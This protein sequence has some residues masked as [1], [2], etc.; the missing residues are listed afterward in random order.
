MPTRA[1]TPA[2]ATARWPAGS[3]QDT[4]R[5][6]TAADR[7]FEAWKPTITKAEVVEYLRNWQ[8]RG[9]KV[10]QGKTPA[11]N[12]WTIERSPSVWVCIRPQD[13]SNALWSVG[14][15]PLGRTSGTVGTLRE[16]EDRV[17]AAWYHLSLE[18]KGP[19][20]QINLFKGSPLSNTDKLASMIGVEA[21]IQ[22]I[23]D[24]HFDDRALKR[25]V[26]LGKLGVRYDKAVV[27]ILTSK[28]IPSSDL[29]IRD[30]GTELST[31]LDVRRTDKDHHRLIFLSTGECLSPDMGLNEFDNS[32]SITR[33]V[34]A[35]EK[36]AAFETA[37]RTAHPVH[38]TV[39]K[40]PKVLPST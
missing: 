20:Q 17:M 6:M 2:I 29:P 28:K 4:I 8:A 39:E 40:E 31:T 5:I 26:T 19:L 22:A 16:L 24:P 14:I 21:D 18:T 36:A 37:W 38:P 23:H 12:G 13:E 35:H 25:L 27:R 34:A 9:Y 1:Q 30:A 3:Q 15:S 10:V 33:I 32:G 7:A 11:I